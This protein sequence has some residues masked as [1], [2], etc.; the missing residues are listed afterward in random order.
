ML[1]SQKAE[2]VDWWSPFRE[3]VFGPRCFVE[4]C[5]NCQHLWRFLLATSVSQKESASVCD[6]SYQLFQV[7]SKEKGLGEPQNSV[8]RFHS[9]PMLNAC[10]VQ[11]QYICNSSSSSAW[12]SSPPPLSGETASLLLGLTARTCELPV[13]Y[14]YQERQPPCY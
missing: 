4:A 9:V 1:F 14:H 13:L 3:L 8:C 2:L 5:V 10:W 11:V 7:P 12:T 6:T